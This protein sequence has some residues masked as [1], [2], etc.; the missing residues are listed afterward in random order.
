MNKAKVAILKTSPETVVDDYV[1]LCEL[2]GMDKA[3]DKSRTTILKDNI[4][5]HFLYP[6][7]NTTPWQLEGTIKALKEM[8]FSDIVDV[9]NRTVVT[10]PFKGEEDNKYVGVYDKYNIPRKFNFKKEDMGWVPFE[11]KRHNFLALHKIFPEGVKIPDYFIGKN[12]IHLPTM[13]THTYT[14]FTG[15]LKNAFGGLLNSRR[16]YTHTWI[17][18]TLVDLLAIQKE[19]HTGLFATMDGTTA[20]EGPGPRTV[21]P[22]DKSVI[23]ASSDMVAIDAVSAKVMGFDPLK[24]RCTAKSH[25]LRLGI[26][27]PS[28]IEI[29]GDAE[30]AEQNWGFR[31]GA[32]FATGTGMLLWRSPLKFIQKLLFHTPLV[33][34]FVLASAVYHDRIWYPGKGMKIVNKW[35]EESKWGR[36][37]QQYEPASIQVEKEKQPQS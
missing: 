4:T 3:L 27:D 22:H 11:P 8:G 26:A 13:K 14:R 17:H 19:I 37:F 29:V 24:I 9:H 33:N 6:G 16:H 7:V 1:R 35:L 2:A 12:I 36:L 10:N 18:D 31:V 20:G 15:A 30:V 21:I 34:L 25:E 23:M 5:W 32:N 28:E